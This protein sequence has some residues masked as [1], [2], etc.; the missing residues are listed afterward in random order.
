VKLSEAIL[1]GSTVLAAK[2]GQQYFSETEAG[3]ALGMA[4]IANG[5]RFRRVAS[6]ID[7][8]DRRTLGVEGVWG[9]WVLRVVMR[10]CECLSLSL[11]RE[12]RI[13][14]V[15]AHLFDGH[16]VGEK[17]WTLDQL[18]AWVQTWEP[19]EISPVRI[20]NSLRSAKAI[21]TPPPVDER[22][23]EQEWQDVRRAFEVRHR[24]QRSST[25]A[26]LGN[27]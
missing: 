18:V 1:L 16:I 8:K 21:S 17:N 25:R 19:K 15:I 11:P 5:C 4:A 13:K 7:E 6:A 2:P 14:D 10:P 3:C 9:R 12:M 23:A 26:F 22:Q 20:V 24:S 27:R